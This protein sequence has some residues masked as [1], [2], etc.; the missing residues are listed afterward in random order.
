M[1]QPQE[2]RA[3]RARRD[4]TEDAHGRRKRDVAGRDWAAALA[5]ASARGLS[6]GEL[7]SELQLSLDHP[8]PG[9]WHQI[10]PQTWL[11]HQQTDLWYEQSPDLSQLSS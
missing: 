11:P 7:A 9:S 5:S 2:L 1:T 10:L 6:T 4:E 8:L 3:S